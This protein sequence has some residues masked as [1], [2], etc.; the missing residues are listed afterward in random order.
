MPFWAILITRRK[1]IIWPI[2][3]TKNFQLQTTV[4]NYKWKFWVAKKWLEMTIF[5][6][7]WMFHDALLV[8]LEVMLH[9]FIIFAIIW[10]IEMIFIEYYCF[11][12]V[13]IKVM[14][15]S[16]VPNM[17]V[18]IPM[19]LLYFILDFKRIIFNKI[20]NWHNVILNCLWSMVDFSTVVNVCL[21]I[22][23]QTIQ[24]LIN[25]SKLHNLCWP[26]GLKIMFDK[27]LLL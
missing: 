8:N 20:H 27:V 14:M 26:I 1:I 4:F 3:A 13:K 19:H 5:L 7:E 6:L 18:Q 22:E 9:K 25:N 12:G 17:L 21:P 10:N 2:F 15:R 24:D 11:I 23:V 16:C